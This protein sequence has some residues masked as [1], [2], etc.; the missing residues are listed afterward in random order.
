MERSP[1]LAN[2]MLEL[3]ILIMFILRALE[4]PT[5]FEPLYDLTANGGGAGYFDF[6]ECLNG[7]IKTGHVAVEDGKYFLTGRGAENIAITEKNLPYS[8]RL[9]AGRGARAYRSEASRS[10][11]I[12][13]SHTIRRSGGYT[14]ELSLSDSEGEIISL[15]IFAPGEDEA[16]SLEKGFRER[17]ETAYN[18]II[19]MILGGDP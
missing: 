4:T 13:A 10:A 11:M 19:A 17:A 7:L 3:K 18:S 12:R 1:E 5:P 2:S 6:V 15:Q 9:K 14:V 16:I 8:L